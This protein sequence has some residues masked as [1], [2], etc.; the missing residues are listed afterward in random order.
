MS[1]TIRSGEDRKPPIGPHSQVQN[2]S[3]M[4][5]ASALSS[6][7][8]PMM[9]VVTKMTFQESQPDKSQRR[10]QTG[11]QRRGRDHADHRQDYEH[12]N[13]ADDRKEVQG[14]GQRA[15]SCGTGH[16]GDCADQAGG[17]ADAEMVPVSR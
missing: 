12:R 2:A 8:R 1:A 10:D 7:L 3:A 9:A 4:K 15:E 16:A 5:T 13:R 6:S 17:R 14:R 11:A